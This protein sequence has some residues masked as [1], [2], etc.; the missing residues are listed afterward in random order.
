MN[1]KSMCC[2]QDMIYLGKNYHPNVLILF[3]RPNY[4][5]ACSKCGNLEWSFNKEKCKYKW[6]KYNKDKLKKLLKIN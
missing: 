4:I 1:K 6:Y 2:K 5:Y 3:E